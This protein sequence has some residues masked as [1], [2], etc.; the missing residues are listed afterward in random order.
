MPELDRRNFLKLVGAG[1][2]A[3]ATVG[4][5]PVEKLVP[6]VIQ[7]EEITPGI[8]VY[9]ASTCTECSARCGMH[10][11]TRE[12]RP[13]KLEGNPKDE[14]NVGSLCARGYASLARTYHPD[15]YTG[16]RKRGADGLEPVAWDEAISV[17]TDRLNALRQ[18]G[19]A[20]RFRVFGGDRGPALG[21]VIDGFISAIGGDPARQRLVDEPF[22]DR[23]LRQATV[24]V[25]GA[26][27][28][29]IFDL[30]SA[31]VILDFGSDFL[32][33]GT[34]S[35]AHA[36]QFAAARDLAKHKHGGARLVSV[37]PR[38]DLTVS[39][40]EQWLPAAAGHEGR[41]ALALA[42]LVFD[43]K[44]GSVSGDAG[45]VSSLLS[46]VDPVAIASAA[47]IEAGDLTAL[48]EKIAQAGSVVALPPGVAARTNRAVA[49]AAAVLLLNAV[50]G[51]VGRAVR[52]PAE[53]GGSQAASLTE[54]QQLIDD[55]NAG[56]VEVLLIHDANPLY[57]LP[58]A[59][60]FAEALAKVDTV[61][62]TASMADETSEAADWVLPDHAPL[63]GWG[64]AS[65][66]G[67][68]L[69]VQPTIRPLHDTQALGDLLLTIGRKV[70]DDVGSQLPSGSFRGVVQKAFGGNWRKILSDGGVF[71][72]V[73]TADGTVVGS[74]GSLDFGTPTLEGDGDYV[75]VA[76]PHSFIGDGAAAS[77]PWAQETPHPVTKSSWVSWA[78]ISL[79]TADELGVT[80]GEVIE[81]ETGFGAGS[82]TVPVYPRGGVRDDVVAV[83]IG[84]GHTVGFYASR[85]CDGQAGEARGASVISVLPAS[86]DEAGGRAWLAT[87]A[88]LSRTGGFQRIPLS[89]WTDNQRGRGIAPALT[90][91]TLSGA[92]DHGEHHGGD[93]H[94]GGGNVARDHFSHSD[95]GMIAPYDPRNDAR[96]DS[97]Y[98]WGMTIDNDR[99]NG[100]SACV[101]ACAGENNI[102]T[103]GQA[104]AIRHREMTWIRIE[105]YIGEGD[106]SGGND[107]RSWPNR[108]KLGEVDVRHAPMLCQHCGAAPC[109]SVCPVIA[110][111]H[112]PEGLNGMV[113]NR[114]VGTR[115]CANNCVYKVRR[116]NYFD[117]G[118]EHFPGLLSLALNPDVTVRGQGV[119]E[120]C[121]FCVQRIAAA[122]Q[123]AKDEGREIRDGEVV[124]ACQQACPTSAITF[125]NTRD[126]QSAVVKSAS[127]DVRSYHSLMQLNARPAITYLAQVNREADEESH[128]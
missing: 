19:Q 64:D 109:E 77:L 26:D 31:D 88:S 104:N 7:P 95:E 89:Q 11:K 46:G 6:Y 100:C 58:A 75:L 96:P 53:T 66:P 2:G 121:T 120:K 110:T 28:R 97:P 123:P 119:M 1:A 21:S 62:S 93:E 67:A 68:H 22:A 52:I 25:F 50:A 37:G 57:S 8:P 40:S 15:R 74:V 107:R 30:S 76:Y 112:T 118:H 60:G 84:Q 69:V 128:G 86:A 23:A 18:K 80:F 65:R 10:V 94:H 39:N 45:T 126:P 105:R 72:D 54:I 115:Y 3:A 42:K 44:G 27:T 90:L 81:I 108:E 79:A 34:S 103:V 32:D 35:V 63:E 99:C 71:G 49:D 82:I 16:P 55:I 78:E 48:A 5:D 113:Y 14:L 122:R 114:C 83:A 17:L 38:M 24:A 98:R 33:T 36:A 13:I 20:D 85:E 116:F 9:Y 102:P 92:G 111:Y 87:R 41:V 12:G 4:C 124:T 51:A 43:A 127:D 125:G 106:R 73:A 29:P 117:Y 61:V 47:G 91:A 56:R 59:L 70:G 101:V